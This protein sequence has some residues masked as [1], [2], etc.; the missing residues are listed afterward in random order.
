MGK[1]ILSK[2]AFCFGLMMPFQGL[3]LCRQYL[4]LA[5]DLSLY[6]NGPLRKQMALLIG[7]LLYYLLD[8]VYLWASSP[9]GL[10]RLRHVD[11]IYLMTQLDSLYPCIF[12]WYIMLLYFLWI[13]LT[14]KRPFIA[15]LEGILIR[16]HHP[17][18]TGIS[19]GNRSSLATSRQIAFW[20]LNAIRPLVLITGLK[21]NNK[22]DTLTLFSL[23]LS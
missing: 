19:L 18:L 3:T 1:G 13:I 17:M 7:L 16:E 15:L 22:I 10:E 4:D 14:V 2:I 8:L 6:Q 11:A 21:H 5:T 12:S 23:S 20:M 9:P